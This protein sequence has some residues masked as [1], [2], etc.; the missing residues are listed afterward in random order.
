MFIRTVII[1]MAV[2][3]FKGQVTNGIL[4]QTTEILTKAI[5]KEDN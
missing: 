3:V 1:L 4:H 2:Q 5:K